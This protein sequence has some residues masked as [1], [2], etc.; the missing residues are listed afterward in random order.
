MIRQIGVET[1]IDSN[2]Q[3]PMRHVACACRIDRFTVRFRAKLYGESQRIFFSCELRE[4]I[5]QPLN[6]SIKLIGCF[7]RTVG[8]RCSYRMN[9][10]KA[11]V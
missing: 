11:N 4:A 5:Q 10:I 6:G 9:T 7:I 2:V 1:V 8:N 3:S